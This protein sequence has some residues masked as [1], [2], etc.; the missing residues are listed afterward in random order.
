MEFDYPEINQ[1][2]EQVRQ[3]RTRQRDQR[4]DHRA[5]YQT[6]AAQLR[7]LG[8]FAGPLLLLHWLLFRVFW[9][10]QARC[11]GCDASQSADTLEC[12]HCGLASWM[13]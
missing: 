10:Q 12:P 5:Q 11:P 9:S 2:W 13:R 6:Q 4:A 1:R 8:M 3:L 7:T